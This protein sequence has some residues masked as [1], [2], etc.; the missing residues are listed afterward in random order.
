MI[1]LMDQLINLWLEAEI[2]SWR[3]HSAICV[4]NTFVHIA[5]PP[6]GV[7]RIQ[8]APGDLSLMRPTEDEDVRPTEAHDMMPTE[9]DDETAVAADDEDESAASSDDDDVAAGSEGETAVAAVCEGS[10]TDAA[11]DKTCEEIAVLRVKQAG[12]VHQ[13][14]VQIAALQ[15]AIETITLTGQLKVVQHM[16]R[17]IATLKRRQRALSSETPVVADAFKRQRLAEEQE[18]RDRMLMIKQ[19][20]ELRK[21][22]QTA[23]AA[24]Q[25]ALAVFAKAKRATQYLETKHACSAAIKT[26][27]METLGAN[28]SKAGGPRA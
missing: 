28:A 7:R 9:A 26:F 22:A 6:I 25:T 24:K 27:S 14:K 8:S 16:E 11:D 1:L 5:T 15:G 4:Y 10:A 17:E 23:V 21:N 12:A 2:C 19:T 13:N 20:K 18:F 3:V